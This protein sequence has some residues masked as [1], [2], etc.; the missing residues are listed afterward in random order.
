VEELHKARKNV[1]RI[2][3]YASGMDWMFAIDWFR[4]SSEEKWCHCM[5]DIL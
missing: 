4:W 1:G 3:F 2:W 5:V